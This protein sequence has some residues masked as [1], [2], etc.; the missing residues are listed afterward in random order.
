[1]GAR[2]TNSARRSRGL[3]RQSTTDEKGRKVP[4]PKGGHTP[5]PRRGATPTPE[6]W[7]TA[8]ILLVVSVEG[9]AE[10]I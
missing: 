3:L 5:T 10:G 7:K 2:I 9:G 6:D 4:T 8:E 1:M